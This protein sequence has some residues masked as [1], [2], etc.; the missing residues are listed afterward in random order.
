M[1][2]D[3]GR[4]LRGTLGTAAREAPEVSPNLLADV[5]AGHRRRRRRRMSAAALAVALI[6][7]GAGVA[8]VVRSAGKPPDAA[9]T[10]KLKPVSPTELGPP[11]KVRTRWPDAVRNLP[12]MRADGRALNP[13]TLLDGNTVLGA[14]A[15]TTEV[16]D[17]LWAYDLRTRT[18]KLI[19]D[20]VVPRGWSQDAADFTVGHG[21]IVWW[22]AART[23]GGERNE[24][25]SAPVTGGPA[26]RITSVV[27]SPPVSLLI[28]GGNVV[29]Y[30]DKGVYQAPLSGGPAEKLPGTDGYSII[31]WPW[32]A[33]SPSSEKSGVQYKV[34]RNVRTGEQRVAT[35]A[36]IKGV[37]SCLVTWCVGRPPI[38]QGDDQDTSTPVQR[39]NGKDGRLLPRSVE[40]A[41]FL[42]QDR[43]LFYKPPGLRTKNYV[44]YDLETEALLDTGI[45]AAGGQE[46]MPVPRGDARD[47]RI[48][49]TT[50]DGPML[51]DL[52]EIR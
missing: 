9:R 11:I 35:V 50:K 14:T 45:P 25:W 12:D 47:Q 16:T 13:I 44:L 42:L 28:D 52:S 32:I 40:E 18:A 30:M 27:G 4:A 33:P 46:S 24:I 39:R 37:W 5:E 17:K 15:S 31:S 41:T 10:G 7:G 6:V 29:W 20:V 48:L 8:G 36:P 19:T 2:D 21:E 49:V 38:D 43:F 51:L 3:L 34:A 22:L 26:R 23:A 1:T